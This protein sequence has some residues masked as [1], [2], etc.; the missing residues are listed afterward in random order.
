MYQKWPDQIFPI[1]N[2]VFSHYGHFG[3]GRG[4][5]GF[6]KGVPP[7]WFLIILK[8]P[9]PTPPAPVGPGCAVWVPRGKVHNWEVME[10]VRAEVPAP[11]GAGGQ[12]C[13]RREG[14]SEPAPEEVK[15]L[16]VGGGC[17]S[18][19][20]D[21]CRLQMLWKLALGITSETHCKIW[22][23]IARWWHKTTR[24][25]RWLGVISD[26]PL[27]G[28]GCFLFRGCCCGHEDAVAYWGTLLLCC[29]GG[30]GGV[31]QGLGIRLFAFGCAYWPLATA[32]SDPLWARTCFGCV[33]GAPG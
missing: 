5:G 11:Q 10:C 7:P 6:G 20:G 31:A 26:G 13:I 21:Y 18:G 16:A 8:K 28:C 2:F 1:V 29:S 22:F 25:P 27:V 15:R 19:W 9:C 33:N 3:L 32:H 30:G 24:R 4:G 17:Q 23:E 12:G 14:A